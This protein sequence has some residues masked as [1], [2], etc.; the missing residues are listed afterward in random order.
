LKA[1]FVK[2]HKTINPIY[3]KPKRIVESLNLSNFVNLY[4]FQ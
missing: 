1:A 3:I 2:V 4:Y